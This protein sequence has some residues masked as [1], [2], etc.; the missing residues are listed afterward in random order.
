MLLKSSSTGNPLLTLNV[1]AGMD[2]LVLTD[3]LCLKIAVFII[4]YTKSRR[5]LAGECKSEI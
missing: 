2:H 4:V 5:D 3:I 1:K